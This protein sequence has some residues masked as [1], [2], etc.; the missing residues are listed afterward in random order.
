M[1][2]RTKIQSVDEVRRWYE[3]GVTYREMSDLHRE[4]YDIEVTPAG[5]SALRR[6]MGWEPR[7]VVGDN[8]LMPWDV[9]ERHRSSYLYLM[10]RR[11]IRRRAGLPWSSTDP[12]EKLDQWVEGLREHGAVVDYRPDTEAGFFLTYG[13]PGIDKDIIREPASA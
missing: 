7:I 4:K 3:S 6:R 1:A 13:R 12:E 5:F 2:G 8:P 11:E 10:L 9:Q